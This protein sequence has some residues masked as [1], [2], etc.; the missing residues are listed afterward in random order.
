MDKLRV[1]IATLL[2]S[3]QIQAKTVCSPHILEDVAEYGTS[4]EVQNI[5]FNELVT[6]L[7]KLVE[8]AEFSY[9]EK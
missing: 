6:Q 3:S 7:L 9:F 4:V 2:F 5:S 8:A 1:L